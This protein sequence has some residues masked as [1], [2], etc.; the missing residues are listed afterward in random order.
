M[1][2]GHRADAQDEASRVGKGGVAVY[3]CGSGVQPGE[4]AK[5]DGHL[6]WCSMSPGRS[7]PGPERNGQ[8][9]PQIHALSVFL[10]RT[11]RLSHRFGRNQVA[12][13]LRI[14]RFSAAC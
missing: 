14:R 1:D 13:S 3:V 11:V 9:G 8:I 7:V 4:D 10:R 12:K 5:A 2:E 6:S